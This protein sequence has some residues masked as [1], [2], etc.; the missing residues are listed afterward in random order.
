MIK[1]TQEDDIKPTPTFGDVVIDQFFVDG[2]QLWQ[3]IDS[4]SANLIAAANGNPLSNHDSKYHTDDPIDRIISKVT[5][6]EF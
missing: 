6:I 2:G 3:K 1:F 5:K 4:T